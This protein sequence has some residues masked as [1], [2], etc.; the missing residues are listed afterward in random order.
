[1]TAA[2]TTSASPV[3][4]SRS[5]SVRSISGSQIT[6]RGC[7]KVPAIFLYPSTFTPFLP[8][9]LASTCP[10]KVVETNPNDSPRM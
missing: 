5:E 6:K 7:L 1:M 8:P 4:N 10:S 2:L 3:R 9:T